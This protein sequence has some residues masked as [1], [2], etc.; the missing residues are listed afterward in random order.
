M[1][2]TCIPLDVLPHTSRLF[3]NYVGAADES[4]SIFPHHY[5][6][7][8][9]FRDAAGQLHYPDALRKS[10]VEVLAEQ[11]QRWGLSPAGEKNLSLLAK[12]G[13]CA[14]VTGQQVGL[15]TGPAF[16]IYKALTAVKLVRHLSEQ[17]IESVPIFWLATEDH[18][19]A[20]VNHCSIQ[21]RDGNPQAIAYP[22]RPEVEGSPAG[23]L[24]LSDAVN[25]SLES[26]ASLLPDSSAANDVLGWLSECY[27]PGE[28][29]GSAFGK[30]IARL[31]AKYGV[32]AIDP[33]DSRVH[34][35]TASLF[36]TVVEK[37]PALRD[38]L[39]ARNQQLITQGLHAQVRVGE[40][41]TLLFVYEAGKR[42]VLQF[43]N[44]EFI[45]STG[46]KYSSAELLNLAKKHPEQLSPTAL[47]RP[48]M[49]DA[50]LPTVAYVGGPAEIAYL[51][52]SVPLYEQLL[53]RMP[54]VV[55]RASVT[56][57]DSPIQRVL[58]KYSLGIADVFAGR[59]Q[60]REKMA[61]KFFSEDLTARF[62]TAAEGL[63]QQMEA[64]QQ[65]LQKLDPTL[66][67]AARNGA[68]KMLY[69]LTS[70]ERKAAASVQGKSDQVE[71][72][73][74]R[75]ENALYPDKSM[76]E[77]VYCGASILA[78]FGMNVM[79]ELYD[80]LDPLPVDH[81]IISPA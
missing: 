59:Q 75:I 27:R 3:R 62:A 37:T 40:T 73:A 76:Q 21:D 78:R 61:A 10:V 14:V 2:R 47:L 26:L 7:A 54:V 58:G 20:E 77:R 49:Q 79:D 1:D 19:L 36:E 25:A 8:E 72:D 55:P 67:E 43:Q 50:L 11:N 44:G 39:H 12:P 24:P 28:T 81:Q 16:A 53:G 71:R 38:A 42:S 69:Q 15:F 22:G 57:L 52:Q 65:A 18:D 31:L 34:G 64:I 48:V 29:L 63:Q 13:C 33:L 56:V 23:T 4:P 5:R 51:A 9:S 32:L 68:Q 45:S 41:S 60:L 30:S 35:L 70:L 6:A 66:V 74:T 46:K 17:G 80:N